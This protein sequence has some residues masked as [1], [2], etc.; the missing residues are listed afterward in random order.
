MSNITEFLGVTS[1]SLP[2]LAPDLTFPSSLASSADTKLTTSTDTSG[3]LTT[4]L[5]LT[6]KRALGALSV[7]LPIEVV[8]VKLTVDG[9]VIFNDVGYSNTISITQLVGSSSTA[10]NRDATSY[11]VE[12]SLL[13]EV[14]T[15]SAAPLTVCTY[16]APPIK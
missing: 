13:L 4:V 3:A 8:T 6:G 16:R 1:G 15:V 11:L 2:K 12:S 14:Q 10:I 5:N 9:D 7:T